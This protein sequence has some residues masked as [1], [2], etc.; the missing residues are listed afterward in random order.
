MLM[1]LLGGLPPL[2]E[3]L[4]AGAMCT[5]YSPIS[6]VAHRAIKLATP[7]CG[8]CLCKGWGCWQGLYVH[9][10]FSSLRV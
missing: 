2:G 10:C 9:L 1:G 3:G 6:G 7:H 5:I 4:L 8:G